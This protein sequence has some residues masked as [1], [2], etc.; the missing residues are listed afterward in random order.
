MGILSK[1][2]RD[3]ISVATATNPLGGI[4]QAAGELATGG[5][6]RQQP[7]PLATL[8]TSLDQLDAAAAL[9]VAEEIVLERGVAS[10]GADETATF[11]QELIEEVARA[12]LREERHAARRQRLAGS[13][14]QLDANDARP[15]PPL[16]RGGA[17]ERPAVVLPPRPAQPGRIRVPDMPPPPTDAERQD[18][19]ERMVTDLIH[20]EEG[21]RTDVYLDTRGNPT[22]GCGH[23]LTTAQR[24]K[25]PVGTVLDE[26]RLDDWLDHDLSRAADECDE[27]FSAEA[28]ARGGPARH[29]VLVSM[30]FQMG[31]A[32][33]SKFTHFH[34]AF[35]AGRYDDAATELAM[36]SDR[37]GPSPWALET[38]H[39]VAHAAATMRTGALHLPPKEAPA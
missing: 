15:R 6:P 10:F 2:A 14:A 8:A 27:L 26:E 35:E 39:R 18:D 31:A 11:L 16:P 37:S 36:N 7:D 13:P 25:F 32:K 19:F 33:V 34:A 12:K 17:A 28:L 30:I 5:T 4:A 22:V 24:G 3:A 20:A 9:Q 21:W 1:V 23:R 38:P 29:A